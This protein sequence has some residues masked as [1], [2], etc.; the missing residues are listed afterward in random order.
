MSTRH[1][2]VIGA[3]IIGASLAYHLARAGARVTVI[4]DR[5]GGQATPASF[6][7]INA[8]FGNDQAYFRLRY[9]SIARWRQLEQELPD[10]GT[11]WGGSITYD[12]S[13]A[14]L[15][16]YVAEFGAR[17]YPLRLVDAAEARILEPHLLAPPHLAVYAEAEGAVEPLAA[18]AALLAASAAAELHTRVHGFDLLGGRAISVMTDDGPVEAD[19]F[20]L[21]AGTATA[22]LLATAGISLKLDAPPGLIL[23]TTPVR[24]L[25]RR[26]IIAPDIHI[27]QS[28]TGEIVA[29]SDFG[30]SPVERGPMTIA[31]E[32]MG[33]IH[34]MVRGSEEVSMARYT[35]GY[36]PT[37]GDG[38][39]IVG[40]VPA[41]EG[42]YV[43]VMHSG[44]T[45]APAIG[46]YAAE[47]I[48]HERRHELIGP[49]GIERFLVPAP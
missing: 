3:G 46:A 20:V 35:I 25:L 32:L 24:R 10:L 16:R 13:E 49:Y 48:L 31:A 38:L 22:R 34:A 7:W 40:R 8:S 5:S 15:H 11:S 39:P 29:G 9:D 2:I 30:G 21:A 23:Y 18:V 12:M 4:A 43:A 44:I 17:G 42:L 41:V 36:R 19:T 28:R 37:P 45:N 14:D 26:L 6:A 27:R 47:E 33:L 1:V